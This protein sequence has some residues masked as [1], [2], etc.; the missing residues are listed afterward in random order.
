MS[1]G[2][3]KVGTTYQRLVMKMFKAYIGD[4]ME[5]CIDDVVVRSMISEDHLRHLDKTFWI[6]P[7][8]YMMHNL[9]KWTFGITMV[10]FVIFMIT[11][12]GIEPC[13]NKI[14]ALRDMPIP[15]TIP[16]I[17]RLSERVAAIIRFIPRSVEK[18][19]MFF[20]LL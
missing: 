10:Q 9:G 18:C 17:Q 4:M 8:Y 20:K 19:Q 11:Q 7:K 2:L 1:F 16:Q 5:V 15:R 12:R 14:K 13:P 6:F 3:K